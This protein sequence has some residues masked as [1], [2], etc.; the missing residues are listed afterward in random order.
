MNTVYFFASIYFILY[1]TLYVKCICCREH[2]IDLALMSNQTISDFN[3]GFH[4]TFIYIIDN[5]SQFK[6]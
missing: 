5:M 2:I 3:L 6:P 1:V 4:N